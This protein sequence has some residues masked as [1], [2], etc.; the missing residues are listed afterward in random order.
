VEV[1]AMEPRRV[2]VVANQTVCGEE[3]LA[4]MRSR[5]ADGPAAFTLVVPATPPHEELTWSEGTARS[6]AERR[7][8]DAL[9]LFQREGI[10]VTG[11]VGDASPLLAIGD[12]LVGG[13]QYDEV[14]LSTL[15][16]KLSRWLRLDLPRRIT[17]R[18]GLPV[19]TVIGER[20]DVT[21][22]TRHT[23]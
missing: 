6:I 10:E 7:L 11:R 9:D 12:L 15:P 20:A 2:V 19:T 22:A 8:A 13:N 18:F 16:T 5:L 21:A 1:I 4:A 3:L 14:I 23:D 17:Q